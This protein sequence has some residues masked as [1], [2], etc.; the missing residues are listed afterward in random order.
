MPWP[1]QRRSTISGTCR[2]WSRNFTRQT[3]H[4]QSVSPAA[5]C[6]YVWL[7]GP[8]CRTCRMRD[9]LLLEFGR[10]LRTAAQCW[11]SNP[12]G[13]LSI[14]STDRQLL[15][16]RREWSRCSAGLVMDKHPC[17]R[18]NVPWRDVRRLRQCVN[19]YTFAIERKENFHEN[20]R[21]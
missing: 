9:R 4:R 19:R 17:P 11:H 15:L 16:C 6:Q 5:E 2:N 10:S 12:M 18:F 21:A 3:Q 20:N 7:S 1:I 14:D 8:P 13:R